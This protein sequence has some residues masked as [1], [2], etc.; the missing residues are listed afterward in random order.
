MT[1]IN[2]HVT[3]VAL[4][5]LPRRDSFSFDHFLAFL[6]QF[7]LFS[8]SHEGAS[9]AVR[10]GTNGAFVRTNPFVEVHV[11]VEHFRPDEGGVTSGTLVGISGLG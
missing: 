10:L 7:V 1:L 3:W 2:P 8:M 5:S 11:I 6:L 9:I 4:F